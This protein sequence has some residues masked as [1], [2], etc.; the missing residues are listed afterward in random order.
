[1]D[2]RQKFLEAVK[3]GELE[4]VKSMLQ[5]EPQLVEAQGGQISARNRLPQG[6]EVLISLPAQR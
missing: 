2:N 5:A 1:M 6:F 4:S 3:A